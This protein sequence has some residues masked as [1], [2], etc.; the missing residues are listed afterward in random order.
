MGVP[1]GPR[2]GTSGTDRGAG[3]P[4]RIARRRTVVPSGHDDD[5]TRLT[6]IHRR[7]RGRRAPRKRPARP[8]DWVRPGPAGHGPEGVRRPRRAAAA[9]RD[10]R[11]GGARR[12]G[13]GLIHGR[14][15]G[16]AGP[17]SLPGRHGGACPG[18]LHGGRARSRRGREPRLDRGRKWRGPRT[19][20][21]RA[22]GDRVD[23]G[24]DAR[25][26]PRQALRRAAPWVGSGGPRPPDSRGRGLGRGAR[27]V[28]GAEARLEGEPES[29]RA[30]LTAASARPRRPPG[31]VWPRR[32]PYGAGAVPT[33]VVSRWWS[34][35]AGSAVRPAW[36]GDGWMTVDAGATSQW[37]RSAGAS[38]ALGPALGSPAAMRRIRSR[39]ARA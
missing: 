33:S 25:W 21:A 14:V 3:R 36:T 2:E 27:R 11:C 32:C 16:A 18:A 9:A 6:P 28:P 29:S 13:S 19:A 5:A 39:C 26:A 37:K 23:E 35:S 34:V 7:P 10:A 38:A 1:A 4:K 24:A 31:S 22:P 12:D 17:P 8:P 15:H 30:G 20:A